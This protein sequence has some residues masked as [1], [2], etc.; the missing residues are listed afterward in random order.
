[1]RENIVLQFGRHAN[2]LGT[3]FWNA[4][5]TYFTQNTQESLIDHHVM[6]RLHST[7]YGK[8]IFTPRVLIYDLRN[9]FGSLVFNIFVRKDELAI[10]VY[11]TPKYPTHPFQSLLGNSYLK[12]TLSSE[13]ITSW[14]DYNMAKYH[15]RS[16]NQL[17]QYDLHD[18][19][20]SPFYAFDQGKDLFR[21]LS[22]ENDLFESHFRPFLEECDNI[23]G[24][25]IFSEINNGWGGFACSFLDSIRDEIPKLCIWTFSI[26]TKIND[27]IEA[28]L[29][30]HETSSLFFILNEKPDYV[31]KEF[32]P[33]SI[34]HTSAFHFSAIESLLIPCHSMVNSISMRDI[35]S[36]INFYSYRKMSYLKVNLK[37][38]KFGCLGLKL[39]NPIE[40]SLEIF[41]GEKNQK[42]ISEIKNSSI[43]TTYYH[44]TKLP[45]PKSFPGI[46]GSLK[47]SFQALA[48]SLDTKIFLSQKKKN[49]YKN[50]HKMR[51][52][53]D[54][55]NN[56]DELIGIYTDEYI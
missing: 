11:Q 50:K 27:D 22:K 21:D 7:R 35:A 12:E 38:S 18:E 28:L 10:E 23:Q 16:L 52:R 13:T 49:I 47:L 6:Y 41:R 34:W 48:S 24:L 45:L 5:E 2:Y 37:D 9:G 26:D 56:L 3:H 39:R 14:S 15:P 29:L 51:N 42:A 33:S 17:C 20:F 30:M 46:F 54:I 25:T 19:T 36:L 4:Q 32:D 43:S 53:D 1:M 55:I 44:S 31:S 40:S 8:D